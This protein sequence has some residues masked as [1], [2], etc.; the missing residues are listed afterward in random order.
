[1]TAEK[2]KRKLYLMISSRFGADDVPFL[3][4]VLCKKSNTITK[5]LLCR[6]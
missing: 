3:W 2:E 6:A 4:L 1:M 5:Q